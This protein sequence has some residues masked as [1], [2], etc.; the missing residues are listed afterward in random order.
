MKTYT[1]TFNTGNSIELVFPTAV[2]VE[3]IQA[4]LS[5]EMLT[6]FYGPAETFTVEE[7]L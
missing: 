7:T 2:S 6:G 5:V 3:D 4:Q 1:I